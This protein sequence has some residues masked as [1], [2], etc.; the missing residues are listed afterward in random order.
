MTSSNAGQG[1]DPECSA[2]ATREDSG[3]LGDYVPITVALPDAVP[4]KEPMNCTIVLGEV[5]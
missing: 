4:L 3:P 5:V 1:Q 2:T